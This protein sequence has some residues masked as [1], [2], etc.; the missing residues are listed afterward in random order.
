MRE[1]IV[2]LLAYALGAGVMAGVM[3]WAEIS[4][5]LEQCERENVLAEDQ[6][7]VISAKVV[8]K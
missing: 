7:C 1:F 6:E 4:P 2:I 3:Y 8:N 5:S